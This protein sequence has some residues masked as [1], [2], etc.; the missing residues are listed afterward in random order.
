MGKNTDIKFVGQPIFKQIIGLLD[1]INLRSIVR[2]HDADRYY[3]AYK[4]KTQ[5]I[6]MLFGI[7]SRCDSMTE[8]CEGLRAMSGKLNHLGF[9]K[10]PAKSTAC[11]GL[12]NRDNKFFED[13]YFN[14]GPFCRT[15]VHL[16]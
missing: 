2:K 12:R 5:L 11:D 9:D 3:K 1:R 10:A 6:T 4:A 8:I 16:G 15:A 7:L 13:V 14:T